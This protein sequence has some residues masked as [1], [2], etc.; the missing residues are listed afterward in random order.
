MASQQWEYKV[1]TFDSPRKSV[2][3]ANVLRQE[4]THGW[5]LVSLTPMTLGGT[6][7]ENVAV[8]KRPTET[9][10]V[11]DQE[12]DWNDWRSKQAAGIRIP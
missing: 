10:A 3:L 11:P 9:P 2:E 1:W 5:E 4:G 7:S 12:I 6:T 8:F